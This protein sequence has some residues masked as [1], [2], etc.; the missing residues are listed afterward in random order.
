[1]R[2][3]VRID[4]LFFS[5]I[6]IEYLVVRDNGLIIVC[7]CLKKGGFIICLVLFILYVISLSRLNFL[8]I[9]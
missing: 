7:K 8:V 1:M 3:Y 4:F 5:D 9:Y 6:I 2:N